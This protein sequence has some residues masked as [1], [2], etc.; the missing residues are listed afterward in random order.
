[1]ANRHFIVWSGG[2]ESTSLLK[3]LLE[4]TDEPVI[5]H[6]IIFHNPEGRNVNETMAVDKL[7]V[8]LKKIRNFKYET[9]EVSICN[10]KALPKD[11]MIYNTVGIMAMN[12]HGYNKFWKGN[13]AEDV[14]VRSYKNGILD[15]ELQESLEYIY[16]KRAEIIKHLLPEGLVFEEVL[17]FPK[18]ALNPKAWHMSYLGELAELTWSCRT[19]KNYQECGKCHSCLERAEAMEGRSFLPQIQADITNGVIPNIYV[20]NT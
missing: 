15:Y 10:G 11:K 18:I 8:Q 20:P 16:V 9:S 13:C 7:L 3:W 4:N 1:M 19:P 2:V 6:R 5:A 17:E 14:Y 12:Y